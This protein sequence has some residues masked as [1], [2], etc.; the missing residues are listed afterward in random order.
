MKYIKEDVEN[1]LKTHK[2]NEAKTTELE[3]KIAE[4]EN[5]L[6]YAGTV[7]E[8]SD[9]E[10]IRSMQLSCN[11]SEAASGRTN[12]ISNVT[13]TTA[14]NYQKEKVHINREDREFLQ[15]KIDEFKAE[16]DRLDKQAVRVKNMINQ[17]TIE[18]R[19]VIE[20]YYTER[21]KWDYVQD[22]Y[23]EEFKIPK[24]A[25]QLQ[26]YKEEALESMLE[27]LNVGMS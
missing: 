17:L 11:T 9:D 5:R 24:N 3:L 23:Y 13:E 27:V 20:T 22:R 25:R 4:Y 16:K 19:F 14:M 2:K 10:V 12:K 6:E 18:Q 26:R 7:H 1:M 21:A 15:Y 8:E